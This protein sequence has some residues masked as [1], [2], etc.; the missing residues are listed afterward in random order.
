[1]SISPDKENI[2][3]CNKLIKMIDE[4]QISTKDERWSTE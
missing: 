4:N 2:R 3:D 1:M